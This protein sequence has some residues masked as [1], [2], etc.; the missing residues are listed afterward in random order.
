MKV[1][2]IPQRSALTLIAPFIAAGSLGIALPSEAATFANF[3]QIDL[4]INHFNQVPQDVGVI[5]D[6]TSI[7][8]AGAGSSLKTKLEG[9]ALFFSSQSRALGRSSSRTLMSGTGSNYFARTDILSGLAGYFKVRA[10][11]TLSFDIQASVRLFNSTRDLA[12][13]PVS[14]SANINLVLQDVLNQKTVDIFDFSG[15]LNTNS[16]DNLNQDLFEFKRNRNLKV[17][18]YDKKQLLGGSTEAL[19]FSLSASFQIPVREDTELA[20]LAVSQSCNYAA[21]VTDVCALRVPEPS[22]KLAIIAFAVC[23]TSWG[24]A[25]RIVNSRIVKQV[26]KLTRQPVLEHFAQNFFVNFTSKLSG[27]KFFNH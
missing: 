23:F 9:S 12:L 26:V 20:L 3:S 17:L 6:I 19:D 15:F 2:L 16:I 4:T 21:N 24:F 27:N 22:N 7:S 8:I 13:S 11:T 5:G 14:T 18:S 25:S 10:N 1:C